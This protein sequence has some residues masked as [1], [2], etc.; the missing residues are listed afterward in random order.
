MFDLK[1]AN[2]DITIES[3]LSK[4]SE[5][6]IWRRYCSNFEEIEKSFCSDLYND[7][8]PACSIYYNRLNEYKF[9]RRSL[10]VFTRKRQ[11]MK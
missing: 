7:R 11:L 5:L 1:D 3:I 9:R 10:F 8:N 2:I 6:E 4:V